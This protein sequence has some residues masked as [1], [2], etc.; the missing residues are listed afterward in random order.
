MLKLA[1]FAPL[2]TL[3]LSLAPPANG[4][5]TAPDFNGTW[6]GKWDNAWCAQFTISSAS[7]TQSAS[8]LYEWEEKRGQPLRTLRRI[9]VLKGERLQI[10]DPTVEIFLSQT[11]D[12]AVAFGHFTVAR[13]AVLKREPILRCQSG[14]ATQQ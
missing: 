2:L 11:P 5:E 6:V 10:A 3:F 14:E 13:S 12:Q 4:V 1:V 7:T 8:V 9:G